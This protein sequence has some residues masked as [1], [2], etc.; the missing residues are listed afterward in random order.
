MAKGVIQ[1]VNCLEELTVIYQDFDQDLVINSK[2]NVKMPHNYQDYA[3]EPFY[4]VKGSYI[5]LI[6]QAIV[7]TL[8]IYFHLDVAKGDTMF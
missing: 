3:M 2:D 1:C 5:P 7:Y 4:G 8:E 6:Y